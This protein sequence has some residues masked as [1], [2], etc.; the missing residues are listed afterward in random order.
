[1]WERPFGRDAEAPGCTSIAYRQTAKPPRKI[2]H[3]LFSASP[4]LCGEKFAFDEG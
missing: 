4:R 2:P 3:T 1:M